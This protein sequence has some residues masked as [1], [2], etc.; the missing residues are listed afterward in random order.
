MGLMKDGKKTEFLRRFS[1]VALDCLHEKL[2]FSQESCSI[3]RGEQ[4]P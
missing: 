1:P 3:F 4:Q 2:G